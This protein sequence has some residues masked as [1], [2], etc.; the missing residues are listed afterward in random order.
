[1]FTSTKTSH[2][3]LLICTILFFLKINLIFK[4]YARAYSCMCGIHTHSAPNLKQ[5]ITETKYH[6]F[7]GKILACFSRCSWLLRIHRWS[8]CFNY[9]VWGSDW[10]RPGIK[11]SPSWFLSHNLLVQ[12]EFLELFFL[13]EKERPPAHSQK[14]TS[15]CPACV[16]SSVEPSIVW[17]SLVCI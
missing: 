5:F 16:S 17:K 13:S 10:T 14:T 15:K 7:S 2:G 3:I 9:S 12:T 6:P 1:M 4:R 8:Y 11:L